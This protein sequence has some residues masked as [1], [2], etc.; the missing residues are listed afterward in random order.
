MKQNPWKTLSSKVVYRNPWITV[1]EDQVI[2]PN[3]SPGIYGVVSP[4]I[5]VG[6]VALSDDNQVYL[7]GQYRYPTNMYSWEIPEGG[8]EESELPLNAIKREL[9]EEAGVSASSWQQLGGEIHLSNCY[10]SEV[11]YLY[12]ARG[13]TEVPNSPDETEVLQVKKVPL[14]EAIA[15]VENSQIVDGLSI[16]GLLKVARL[17][18]I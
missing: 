11:A 14:C 9:Q 5:A 7:V 3:G 15:A 1:R 18:G 4:K 16:M 17:I 12:L 6:V 10:T 13:L 8:V 2:N